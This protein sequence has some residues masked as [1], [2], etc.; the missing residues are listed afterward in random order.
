[1]TSKT[2]KNCGHEE[3]RHYH[4]A[5]EELELSCAVNKCPCKKFEIKE[6]SR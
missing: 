4:D 1:M 3:N 2:C 5:F 6:L